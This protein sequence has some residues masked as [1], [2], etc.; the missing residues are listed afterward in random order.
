MSEM[1]ESDAENGQIEIFWNAS[2]ASCDV[3]DFWEHNGNIC[4][5]NLVSS[6]LFGLIT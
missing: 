2:Y 6:I 5:L 4:K 1:L 3:S